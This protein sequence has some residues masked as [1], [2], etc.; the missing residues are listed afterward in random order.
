MQNI[1]ST[2]QFSDLFPSS[3]SN[4]DFYDLRTKLILFSFVGSYLI[5]EIKK[6]YDI[7]SIEQRAN[8]VVKDIAEVKKFTNIF[9]L[10]YEQVLHYIYF[11]EYPSKGFS[12]PESIFT[13][14]EEKKIETE[15]VYIKI[16]PSL[17]ARELRDLYKEAKKKLKENL[18]TTKRYFRRKPSARIAWLDKELGIY[19]NIEK[20]LKNKY[21]DAYFKEE[22]VVAYAIADTA[23]VT[24][25]D[26]LNDWIIKR[27]KRIYYEIADEYGLPKFSELNNFISELGLNSP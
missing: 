24:S 2:V 19:F 26:Y 25:K 13:V 9:H 4:V 7:N 15:G 16:H 1:D 8:L 23:K 18:S 17:T 14:Y 12:A 21:S 27:N 5:N 10:N 6:R 11:N 20:D 22:G 3:T